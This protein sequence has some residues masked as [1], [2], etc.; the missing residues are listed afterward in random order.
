MESF[1]LI[2]L[3]NNIMHSWFEFLI[4]TGM[5][6]KNKTFPAELMAGS[7]LDWNE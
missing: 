5:N 2:K 4:Q 6:K 3:F 7:S 1:P